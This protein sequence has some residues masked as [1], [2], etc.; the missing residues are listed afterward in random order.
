MHYTIYKI[1]N[2]INNK[3][4]IGKHETHDLNDGYMGSGKLIRAAISKYGIENFQK[5]ILYQFGNRDEM[6]AKEAELVTEEFCADPT[7]YNIC[8]GGHGGFGYI[9]KHGKSHNTFDDPEIQR[10]ASQKGNRMKRELFLSNEDWA[11]SYRRRLSLAKQTY[12]ST[13][14]GS[15]T[16]KTHTD[17]TKRKIG[18]A[19]SLNQKGSSNSQFGSAWIT[20]GYQNKKIKKG[21]SIPEGWYKGR[22]K[23]DQ[24]I[25]QRKSAGSGT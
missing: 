20:N 5:E 21:D 12:H 9:N 6:N 23:N 24:S 3:I 19:S 14:P 2:T 7:N 11:D 25:A 15:F 17:E 1:T 8:P 4:Y 22:S 18:A 10:L 16:G 13:N